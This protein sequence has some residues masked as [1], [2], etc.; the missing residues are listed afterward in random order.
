M[1][2]CDF[3]KNMITVTLQLPP[4][5]VG[6][7]EAGI[8]KNKQI[9]EHTLLA[10]TLGMKQLI[11]TVNKMDITEPPYSS[12][13]FEEISKEVKAYIKKISYNSQTLP[14][15]PIS[16]WHGDNML[17]PG[18]KMPWFEGCVTL[19]KALDSITLLPTP[20]TSLCS[21]P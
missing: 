3:I 4:G 8:S 9:C 6:E 16:G 1:G 11:V 19:L 15:V 20:R 17:E 14:F 2:H 21:C 10:Y 5:G 18:S 7:C 13:C 12:T